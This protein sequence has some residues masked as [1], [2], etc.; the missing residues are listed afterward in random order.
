MANYDASIRV[1]TKIDTSQ[2]QKLQIQIDKAMQKVAGLSAKYEELKSKKIPTEEYTAISNQIEKATAEFDKLISKQDE[3]I[4]TGKD[5]GSAWDAL[6]YKLEEA[7]NT[8]KYA[9]GELQDLVDSG[10]AF[11]FGGSQEDLSKAASDLSMAQAELRA[12]NTKQEELYEKQIKTEAG[13]KKVTDRFKKLGKE[14]GKSL[15]NVNRKAKKTGG[16]I[17]TLASRFKG[18]A[19]SLLIFN[20]I[21]KAFNTMVAGMKEGFNNLAKYSDRYNKTMSALKSA[22]TQ[23]KNSFATAF[24]PIV[25]TVIPHLVTLI[26]YLTGAVNKVAQFTAA[27]TGKSVWI[28]A[29]TVQEDY[30]GALNGTAA[31]AKKA[32]G[33]LAGFDDLDVLNKNTSSSGGS[34]VNDMFEEVEIDNGIADAA[35]NVAAWMQLLKEA[36]QPAA[37]ALERLWNEGFKQ[38]GEFSTDT[39]Q[40]LYHNFIEP[41]GKWTLGAGLPRLFDVTNDLLKKINWGKLNNSL[42]GMYT[43]LKNIAEMVF[44][45]VIDL[46]EEFFAPLA[47]WVMNDALPRLVDVFTDFSKQV[48]WKQLNKSVQTFYKVLKKYT[49]G[50]G[51]GLLDF[52]STLIEVL[53]PPVTEIINLAA[54]ALEALFNVLD[55]V[56]EEAISALGGAVGGFLTVFITNKGASVIMGMVKDAWERLYKS[57]NSGLDLLA[58]HPYLALAAGITALAGALISLEEAAIDKN[59]MEWEEK[60]IERYGDTVENIKNKIVEYSDSVVDASSKRIEAV[61]RMAE[62]EIPYLKTLA[63]KYFELAEKTDLSS[64]EYSELQLSAQALVDAFPELEQYYNDSTGL[65]DMNRQSV[66]NLIEAKERELMISALGEKWAEGVKN[67]IEQQKLLDEATE[68]LT[69]AQKEL[70]AIEEEINQYRKKNGEDANLQ[71]YWEVYTNAKNTVADFAEAQKVAKE[72][73]QAIEDEISYYAAAWGKYSDETMEAGANFSSGMA[74]GISGN[75]GKIK[76]AAIDMASSAVDSTKK[77][78]DIHSPSKVSEEFGKYYVYGFCNGITQCI[79]ATKATVQQWLEMSIDPYFA[80]DRW[81]ELAETMRQGFYVGLQEMM[82]DTVS[83]VNMMIDA[84]QHLAN[85]VSKSLNGTISGYNVVATGTGGTTLPSVS[86]VDLSRLPQ[87][88]NGAVLRGGNPHLAWL[89]DQPRG[90]TNVEA[91]S[92]LIK[93]MVVEGIKEAGIEEQSQ[94]INLTLQCGGD[95]AQVAR[96]FRPY[97]AAEDKRIGVNFR[98]K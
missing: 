19:L 21:T 50:I 18:I 75:I 27:L 81:R 70:A 30:A 95:M 42:G 15:D 57:L 11:S 32:A 39:L 90:Q 85:E 60:Q 17:S 28:K 77:E 1:S 80:A 55:A 49:I 88:A 59:N 82:Q 45:S 46:Y 54:E 13:V 20:W 2:M 92:G 79:A 24:A 7:G 22:N 97:L 34:G 52:A 53:T 36:V 44:D 84:F 25:Q 72:A 93:K 58:S 91:P 83:T 76:E 56:P 89:G 41:L 65:L 16:M 69:E 98:I 40:D 10:K 38:L 35:K 63:D 71:D 73:M 26:N 96:A 61:N 9:K 23:L 78:L 64:T 48:D 51:G 86:S 62:V 66:E 68:N 3:M 6:Q 8:I 87:Y 47:E 29:T 4:A 37:E 67:K 43:E 31:A 14:G 74:E 12:L 94:N 5:S 33:A